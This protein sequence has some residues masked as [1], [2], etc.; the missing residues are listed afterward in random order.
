MFN[1]RNHIANAVK[2]FIP[3]AV[4]V[5]IMSGLVYVAVQQNYRQNANDPQIEYAEGL[6]TEFGAATSN[7]PINPSVD[8]ATSLSTFVATYDD[9]GK[10]LQSSG[11][12]NNKPPVIP[13]GVFDAAKANASGQSR[14]TWQPQAGV[15]QA[16]VIQ[17]Y[18]GA[19]NGYVVVGRSLRET[20]SRIHMLGWYVFVAWLFSLVVSFGAVI[21]LEAVFH[22][23]TQSV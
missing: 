9:T 1:L 15:R 5:T 4:V 2:I 18:Q 22:R 12:L 13:S 11:L 7:P 10:F 17:R 3:L 8:I 19:Q 14:V 16:L 23:W 20:E 21:V 6:A